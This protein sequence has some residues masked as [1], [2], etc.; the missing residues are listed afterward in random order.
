MLRLVQLLH[1]QCVVLR[2]FRL[3]SLSADGRYALRP[4][5]GTASS[6][7]DDP[8][9]RTSHLTY[10]VRGSPEVRIGLRHRNGDDRSF[11]GFPEP[12]RVVGHYLP[13]KSVDLLH[14]T[15]GHS[16][17]DEGGG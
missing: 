12:W 11:L 4:L 14:S 16:C 15:D 2:S 7:G 17:V 3:R 10:S 5:F 1:G 6:K 9:R 8:D 13:G